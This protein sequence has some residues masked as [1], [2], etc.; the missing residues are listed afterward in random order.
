MRHHLEQAHVVAVEARLAVAAST[1]APTVESSPTRRAASSVTPGAST[2]SACP[3]AM[4]SSACGRSSARTRRARVPEEAIGVSRSAS[5]RQR[6]HRGAIVRQRLPQDAQ[7]RARDI[8][9]A[10]RG[11]ER[12]RER[13][14]VAHLLE[15][16]PRARRHR[17]RAAGDQAL[18]GE[19]DAVLAEAL[20]L[21]QRGV[22]GLQE[23]A[24]IAAVAGP[25]RDPERQRQ[26]PAVHVDAGEA[27]LEAPADRARVG[28]GRLGQEQRELLAADAEDA[29]CR[30]HAAPQEDAHLAQRVVARDM[31]ARVVELLEVVDVGQHE[32]ESGRPRG[33][34]PAHRLVE[35]A[36][37]REPGERVRRGF[38]L[39]PLEGAQALERDRRVRDEQRGVVDDLGMQRRAAAEADE[40]A[41][42]A[43]RGA[44]RQP[45]AAVLEVD[46]PLVAS[47]LRERDERRAV[48]RMLSRA[49]VAQPRLGEHELAL[50]D[51]AH[52][53]AGEPER[54]PDRARHDAQ[55]GSVLARVGEAREG[56][57]QPATARRLPG[58]GRLAAERVS[59]H[60]CGAPQ[61]LDVRLG[62]GAG[63]EQGCRCRRR[64]AA[65]RRPTARP[66]R[67]ARRSSRGRAGRT[68]R[69]RRRA[70]PRRRPAAPGGDAGART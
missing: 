17:R 58:L 8:R 38:E 70:A 59:E 21:V 62:P 53:H 15:R 2:S 12:A 44:Q 46:A 42:R 9:G 24:Q 25:A 3:P 29:V 57:P 67:G 61:R 49:L 36:V 20:G 47:G 27:A 48:E 50:H 55:H 30:A 18:V 5:V 14:Q 26:P 33:H 34:E 23:V 52:L 54:A 37:V 45:E 1:T 40:V 32:R 16:A 6:P 69:G 60:G 68:V 10:L 65:R 41:V 63:D 11:R 4:T 56:L 7:E 13:L 28:L 22:G 64:R 66:S 35:A 31:P 19:R 43:R 39:L 51:L